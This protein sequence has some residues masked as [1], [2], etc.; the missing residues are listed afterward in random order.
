MSSVP[1]LMELARS[2]IVHFVGVSGAGMSALAQMLAR[3]GAQVTGCDVRPGAVAERL[4][5]HGIPVLIGHDPRHVENVAAVIATAAV[6]SDHPELEAA[7]RR[8]V[9]VIKRASALASL[10]N[11][12]T[13]VGVA[14]THGK[15]TTTA[16]TT[17]ILAEAGLEPTGF[18]GGH[19]DEWDGGLRAGNGEIFVVEAD[20]YDRSFLALRPTI[21]VVTTLEADHLDIYGS[22]EAVEEAFREFVALVPAHGKVV[23]CADDAGVRRLLRSIP[24]DNVIAYGLDA[25][26]HVH[27][28]HVEPHGR[29]MQFHIVDEGEDLG[30]VH[31]GAPGLHNVRNALAAF[32]AARQLGATIDDAARGLARFRGVNRR[33]QEMGTAHGATIVD[34]YAHH[35]TEVEATLEAAR[36]MFRDRRVVVVFQPHLYSR[37]RDFADAFGRVLG[38]ADV[39]WVTDV[40]AAREAPI[41][42]VTGALIADAV[43]AAGTAVRYHPEIDGLADALARE[44]RPDDVC[45]TM[46]AGDIDRVARELLTGA[47]Q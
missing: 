47:A 41:E 45:I 27:A 2:G 7:R 22:L 31:L 25:G 5:A 26:A 11:D 34:D 28:T 42:G 16:M 23:A 40:Y 12:A 14:G 46:G 32:V 13:V 21:A 36:G 29:G 17:E 1:N 10:V 44:L 20:E 39:V 8:G 33:F 35:P 4:E 30:L 38:T 6:R 9:P 37:T 24:G 43:R 19:V 3:S 15:T 18:V